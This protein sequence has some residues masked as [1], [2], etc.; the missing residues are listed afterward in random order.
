MVYIFSKKKRVC[1]RFLVL[2]LTIFF[3]FAELNISAYASDVVQ[4]EKF[5]DSIRSLQEGGLLDD[6]YDSLVAKSSEGFQSGSAVRG[7][8]FNTKALRDKFISELKK[9]N[10][11]VD[12]SEFNVPYGDEE[13]KVALDWVC[14]S[15]INSVPDC[16][17]LLASNV[18]Y[19]RSSKTNKIVRIDFNPSIKDAAVLD[20]M[21]R[22]YNAAIREFLRSVDP[23][24]TDM[25]KILYINEYL[26]KHCEYDESKSLDHRYDAYG[27]LVN[28]IAVC[29]GYALAYNSLAEKLGIES[30]AVTSRKLNHAWNMVKLNGK[31]YMVDSTWNDPTSDIF[32]RARHSYLLK[33][34]VW[35]HSEDG[36]HVADDFVIQDDVSPTLASDTRYDDC[37][38]NDDYVGY[39]YVDGTWYGLN[40]SDGIYTYIC[41]GSTWKLGKKVIDTSKLKWPL[42]DNRYYKSNYSLSLSSY[43]GTLLYTNSTKILKYDPK[44]GE[45]DVICKLSSADSEYGYI[46]GI[47][48]NKQELTYAISKV[49]NPQKKDGDI[50][51]FRKFSLY[52]LYKNDI[53]LEAPVFTW[54]DDYKTVN[55]L[56]E[57][58]PYKGFGFEFADINTVKKNTSIVPTCTESGFDEYTVSVDFEGKT[59]SDDMKVTI[60]AL[61]HHGGTYV[62]DKKAA[63]DFCEGYTGDTY[64]NACG[65]CIKTGEKIPMKYKAPLSVGKVSQDGRILTDPSGV[66]YNI[67]VKL[68]KNQL[69]KNLKVADKKS[70]GKYKITKVNIKSGKVTGGTLAYVAPFNKN[71]KNI[72]VPEKITLAGVKFEVSSIESNAFKNNKNITSIV[73]GKNVKKIGSNAFRNCKKLKKITVKTLKL[74]NV[75]VNAFK[76]IYKNPTVYMNKKLG[77]KKYNKFLKLFYKAGISKKAKI[78]KKSY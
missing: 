67:S 44:T 19:Y 75:G 4:A 68:E 30:Y 2:C 55:V 8:S 22:E 57:S 51:E 18:L 13:D 24:W 41:D 47:A 6:S 33:S 45:S 1:I 12:I 63:S 43:Y 62:K 58:T 38:W 56:F 53:K 64:C 50:K 26:D 71:S 29:Q 3:C 78:K 74:T 69:K 7:A 9:G 20:K 14:V 36:G 5:G 34:N 42:D 46:Y 72:N 28:H 27:V 73:I 23:N 48:R 37:I 65:Q 61:G 17:Y 52:D 59:Y 49:P 39:E 10:T 32:G 76:G 35:F 70:G 60:A 54:S 21:K 77:V 15:A 16:F 66:K 31:Y 11:V 40:S 25:E